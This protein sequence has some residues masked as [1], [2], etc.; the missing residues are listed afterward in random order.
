ME[1]G[2]GEKK[3]KDESPC[4]SKLHYKIWQQYK[5][6]WLILE[7]HGIDILK[8]SVHERT[9][10]KVLSKF[11]VVFMHLV[12]IYTICVS[13][14]LCFVMSL[15][16]VFVC[17]I[18]LSYTVAAPLP[19]I[20]HYIIRSK[21]LLLHQLVDRYC[22]IHAL[23]ERNPKTETRKAVNF[24]LFGII[25]LCI[26]LS[27]TSALTLPSDSPLK[28]FYS[29]CDTFQEGTAAVFIRVLLTLLSFSY[30]YVYPGFVAVMCGVLFYEFSEILFRYQKRL[31]ARY[32]TVLQY[33]SEFLNA[34]NMDKMQADIRMYTRLFETVHQL[35]GAV[36]LICFVFLCN[37]TIV[38]FCSL[39]DFVLTEEKYFSIP[40]ICENTL[41]IALVPT[42]LLGISFCASRIRTHYE[43]VQITLSLLID[44]L[45]EENKRY[46]DII[47]SLNNMK[48]KSFPVLS[49]CG[50]ADL[51]PK[52]MIGLFGSIFTYGLLILNL[53]N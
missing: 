40:K 4:K 48:K 46:A 43:N 52:F 25:F 53:K 38:M 14:I 12:Q 23:Q 21:N 31:E 18:L 35:Q 34:E 44:A 9:I 6:L 24:I 7:I 33:P 42:S 27:S 37:Q 19:L 13:A 41:I 30:Q 16:D 3:F 5:F 28:F 29:F 47:L 36:S 1:I 32:A 15:Y 39:S 10:S 45:L 49:A 22:R 2:L 17:K 8:N 50:I 51:S 26:T 11:C 20:L